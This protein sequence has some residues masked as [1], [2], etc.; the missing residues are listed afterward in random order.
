[1]GP[2][3]LIAKGY[4]ETLSVMAIFYMIIVMVGYKGIYICQNPSNYT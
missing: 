2:G 1:M 4:K 3:G